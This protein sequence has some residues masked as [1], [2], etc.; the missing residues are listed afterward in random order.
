MSAQGLTP[1]QAVA[2]LRKLSSDDAYRRRF[3][4]SPV[5][6]LQEVGVP[7]AVAKGIP[8]EAMNPAK[9]ADAQTLNKL[10]DALSEESAGKSRCMC[11]VIPG[12]ALG[13]TK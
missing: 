6:A 5:D 9:L 7:A 3:E 10:A 11:M 4:Q 13:F 8:P 1:Q 2:F 12:V